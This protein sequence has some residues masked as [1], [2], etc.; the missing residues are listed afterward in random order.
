MFKTD[1]VNISCKSAVNIL[2]I[3]VAAFHNK[4]S[5][6]FG[7]R[8]YKIKRSFLANISLMK[9]GYSS[10]QLIDSLVL[11]KYLT[12]LH[13]IW[14]NISF[15]TW[16]CCSS[17]ATVIIYCF[18]WLNISQNRFFATLSAFSFCVESL[19]PNLNV[20]H[21]TSPWCITPTALTT[22]L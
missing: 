9:T 8:V 4:L 14:I 6:Q 12:K 7:S 20:L 17:A 19:R 13:L 16:T 5:F 1:K 11:L 3:S 10:I 21:L 22:Q 15:P 2:C 18:H